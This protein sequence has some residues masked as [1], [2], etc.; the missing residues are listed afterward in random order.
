MIVGGRSGG[1]G[2]LFLAVTTALLV[3][4]VVGLAGLHGTNL[5]GFVS[6][7]GFVLR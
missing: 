1:R 2:G 4:V 5:M 7:K 3:F 6:L